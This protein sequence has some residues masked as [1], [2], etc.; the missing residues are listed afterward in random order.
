MIC[1]LGK[2]RFRVALHGLTCE[3]VTPES[4]GNRLC[5][6]HT[7]SIL[8]RTNAVWGYLVSFCI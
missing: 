8:N 2:F 4:H 7:V 5:S 3:T 1:E 6:G